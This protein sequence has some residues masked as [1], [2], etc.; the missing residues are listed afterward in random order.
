ME[1]VKYYFGLENLKILWEKIR[2]TFASKDSL[3][4]LDYRVDR[5]ENVVVDMGSLVNVASLSD[6]ANLQRQIDELKSQISK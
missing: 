3:D 6:I 1:N 5:L 2:Q 4:R